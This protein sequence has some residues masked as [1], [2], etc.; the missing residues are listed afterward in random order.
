[1]IAN[2]TTSPVSRSLKIVACLF[3]IG[4][5]LL[6]GDTIVE[7]FFGRIN[8]NFGILVI[9]IGLGLLRLNRRSLAWALFLTRIGLIFTPIAAVVALLPS[10]RFQVA[11]LNVDPA[12]HGFYFVL[13]LAMF[14]LYYWQY[15]VLAVWRT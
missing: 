11:G 12:A 6:V 7:L 5:F 13:S 2:L 1:M 14:A 10:T 4:G 3:L 8:F 15:S 9:I